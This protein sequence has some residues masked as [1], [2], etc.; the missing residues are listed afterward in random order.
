MA[1]NANYNGRVGNNTSNTRYFTPGIPYNLWTTTSYTNT[2]V[3]PN[4]TE[5][6]L[7]PSSANYSS[8]YIPG[9]LVVDGTI[10][11]PSDL[12]LK[13][14]I[15]EISTELSDTVMRLK[16]TQFTYK[17]D[18]QHQVHYGFIAQEFE[19]HLPELVTNKPTSNTNYNPSIN[20]HLE[21]NIKAI[22]YLEVLPLLVH[23]IQNMQK[24]IDELK[25]II[26]T[27]HK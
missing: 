4:V 16:P 19:E 1:T 7:T 21:T 15:V 20:K 18:T 2:S 25:T 8:V 23:K 3:S 26:K 13:E 11:N 6:V 14:N 9:N 22:N 12:S 24:E 17:S 5:T 27:L 10:S